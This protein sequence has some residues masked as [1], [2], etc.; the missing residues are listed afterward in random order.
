MEPIVA[1]AH[2]IAVEYDLLYPASVIPPISMTPK[3][4]TSAE[5]EPEI[6]ANI[7]DARTF[8]KA[9]PPG[10]NPTISEANLKILLVIPQRFIISPAKIYNGIAIKVK[11]SAPANMRCGIVRISVPLVSR[12][13]MEEI[14][15]T[16]A[17]G[18]PIRRSAKKRYQQ[19]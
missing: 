17:T 11:E 6:P 1:D 3:E 15:I 9:R 2:V 12:Y 5:V 16:A 7:V 18:T 13:S 14:P 10:K 8:T 19:Y 4:A